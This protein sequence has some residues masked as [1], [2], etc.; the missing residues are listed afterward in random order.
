MRKEQKDS[1]RRIAHIEEN[2]IA[3]TSALV[4]G[5]E[6]LLKAEKVSKIKEEDMKPI[7]KKLVDSSALLGH[8]NRELSERRRAMIKPFLKQEYKD[9]C[10]EETQI[11]KLIFGDEFNQQ[12]ADLKKSSSITN[13][14]MR[15]ND[16]RYSY[17]GRND[18]YRRNYSNYSRYHNNNYQSQSK[19]FLSR[20]KTTNFKKKAQYRDYNKGRK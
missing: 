19:P 20:G 4:Q 11:K 6:L 17:R 9:L 13:N 1:D 18:E 7:A 3:A 16:R 15:Y 8:V 14:P 12:I 2:V 10:S 5:T